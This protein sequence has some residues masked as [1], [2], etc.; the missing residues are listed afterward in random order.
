M[1]QSELQHITQ[2]IPITP[3]EPDT[4]VLELTP[5]RRR[6]DAHDISGRLLLVSI[7]V[8]TPIGMALGAIAG[9]AITPDDTVEAV[10]HTQKVLNTFG[11]GFIGTVAGIL[12]GVLAAHVIDRHGS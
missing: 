1:T 8:T 9:N 5:E 10:E 11:G 6:A 4:Q 3:S 12:G 7:A 2:E